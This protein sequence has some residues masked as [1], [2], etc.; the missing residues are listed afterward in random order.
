M[1]GAQRYAAEV[2]GRERQYIKGP[3]SWLRKGCWQDEP[4]APAGGV[5]IDQDGNVVEQPQPQGPPRHR[6]GHVDHM[7]IAM[8][9]H[10]RGQ[11]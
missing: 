4:A 9:P 5:T 11:R 3:G 7:A 8:A 10:R 1:A 2:S 6:G